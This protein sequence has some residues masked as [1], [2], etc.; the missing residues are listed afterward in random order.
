MLSPLHK[1]R[2]NGTKETM[3]KVW[4][5]FESPH[6]AFYNLENSAAPKPAAVDPVLLLK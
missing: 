2:A 5:F 3:G 1:L 6:G 4:H